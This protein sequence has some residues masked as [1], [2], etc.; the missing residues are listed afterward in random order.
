MDKELTQALVDKWRFDVGR[1]VT[2]ESESPD[3]TK[4]KP[5]NLFYKPEK[6]THKEVSING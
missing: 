4:Y 6:D 5:I 3:S 2:T 1:G